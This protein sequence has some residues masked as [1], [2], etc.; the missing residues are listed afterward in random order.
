M[1]LAVL[2]FSG[3]WPGELALD[4]PGVSMFLRIAVDQLEHGGGV[5]YWLP[6]MWTG[7][8]VWALAPSFPTLALAPL[9]ILI[10]AEAAVKWATL[11]AQVV[12]GWGAFVLASSLWRSAHPGR[13]P[14]GTTLIALVAAVVYALHPI[15]L[16]H[17]AL[18]GHQTSLWVMAITPWLA[19]SLRRALQ[20]N[21]TDGAE[22]PRPRRYAVLAGLLAAAAVLQQAEHAYSL[23]LL[24]AFQL[25]IELGKARRSGIP[26]GVRHLL[27]QACLVVVVALGAVAFWLFPFLSLSD[28]FI[29]TPPETVRSVLEEGVGSFL[30]NEPGTF[31]SRATPLDG[32]V[33]FGGDLL[34]GNVYLSWVCLVPTFVTAFLLGRH[35]H[36]GHLSA[37]LVAGMIGVWLSTAG[38]P[39]AD[40]GPAQRF[41]PLP[42]LVVG[43]LTGLVVGSCLRRVTSGRATVVAGLVA[44]AL[45]VSAPYVT[46]FLA[47]Q[48]VVPLL[49]NI[50][51]PRFYPVAA[52]GLALGA[53]YPLR[54]VGPW[55]RRHHSSL[56]PA[57]T[58]AGALLLLGAF[59]VD[60]HPY[61][62]FYR[63]G[64][65]EDD[66][67]YRQVAASLAAVGGDFR[68]ATPLFGDARQ[69]DS[70]QGTGVDLSVGWPHPL[71]SRQAWR[72]TGEAVIAPPSYREAALGLA[73]TAYMAVERV[74]EDRPGHERVEGVYLERNPAALPLVRAYDQAVVVRDEAI[75]AELAVSL[76]HRN[77]TVV[78]AGSRG[79]AAVADVAVGEFLPPDA[80][81]DR[82]SGSGALAG[83]V[84]MA[85]ALHNW[86]GVFAAFDTV[87]VHD[88]IGFDLRSAADGLAGIGLWLDRPPAGTELVLT[89]A[90]TGEEVARATSGLRDWDDNSM[91]AFR[92]PAIESSAGQRYRATLSCPG[93]EP[94]EV[95][96][97]FV[98]RGPRGEGNV[99]LDGAVRDDRAA[100][101]SVIHEG[102]PV[103]DVPST[104]LRAT[105]LGPGHWRVAVAGEKPSLVVVAEAHFPGWRATV[106]GE[107]APVLK[108]D[109]AFL[110]VA[111]PPGEH[112]VELVY[113]EPVAATVGRLVTGTTLVAILLAGPV[114]RARRRRRPGPDGHG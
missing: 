87:P 111:V 114:S 39:L 66:A 76:A 26:G 90:T 20:R 25:L 95:P 43:G 84:A 56:A 85:C 103:A 51:F 34:T 54:F 86:I 24:C 92:F 77:V 7:A 32:T 91:Y 9:G 35:D 113:G 62:T 80:C 6:E 60:I 23:A 83:E 110:G 40:S 97:L 53:A 61:R 38:V 18:F 28:S 70:L 94:A 41:E 49:E 19:W 14:E 46:P 72:L 45:M 75:A 109:G 64:P 69:V 104:A 3:G 65:P 102:F 88:G 48:R 1:A 81:D 108:A 2:G 73:A 78:T 82:E 67:A 112:E 107:P 37:I 106:D 42:F 17:G 33:D 13:R 52:L 31:L 55:A 93:C 59:L 101:F 68:V 50:R 4:G 29:L 71:A 105:E 99:V 74:V 12:G 8:P 98:S 27:G 79:A 96:S 89:S 57:L 30:G 63:V 22:A 36:D 10:G 58:A 100:A 44:T 11:A 16:S 15:F 47:L 5:P 21:R